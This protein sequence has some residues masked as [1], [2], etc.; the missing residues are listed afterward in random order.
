VHHPNP[1]ASSCKLLQDA[2][3]LSGWRVSARQG[4]HMS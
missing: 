1:L 4:A 3:V 2:R